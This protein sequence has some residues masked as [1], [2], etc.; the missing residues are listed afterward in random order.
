MVTLSSD[1]SYEVNT[2]TAKFSKDEQWKHTEYGQNRNMNVLLPPLVFF[3]GS[4]K[5][6]E[7]CNGK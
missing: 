7:G 1:Q 4:L 3:H 2:G 5:N 6:Q